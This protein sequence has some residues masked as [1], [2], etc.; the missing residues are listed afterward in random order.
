MPSLK[1]KV[2]KLPVIG[3]LLEYAEDS[4]EDFQQG[5]R[6]RPDEDDEYIYIYKEYTGDETCWDGVVAFGMAYMLLMFWAAFAAMA[7]NVGL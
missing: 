4:W 5:D 3:P 1:E 2:F 6:E 7:A